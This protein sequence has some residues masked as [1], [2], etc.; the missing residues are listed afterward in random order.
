EHVLGGGGEFENRK[1]PSPLTPPRCADAQ[2]E[3]TQT[4][5]RPLYVAF[6]TSDMSPA[7]VTISAEQRSVPAEPERAQRDPLERFARPFVGRVLPIML[8]LLWE[9]AVDA[10]LSTGRLVPPPSVIWHTLVELART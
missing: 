10:G 3:G 9:A 7:D 6:Q 1:S 8:A 5:A 2:G 4:S